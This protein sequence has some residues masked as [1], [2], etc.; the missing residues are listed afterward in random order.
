M[1]YIWILSIL[2]IAGCS[3]ETT[4]KVTQET[5]F[6]YI[7]QL[8]GMGLYLEPTTDK[9]KIEI[10][11]AIEIAKESIC[12]QCD[13]PIVEYHSVTYKEGNQL[14]WKT[15]SYIVCFKNPDGELCS[16]VDA[17]DGNVSKNFGYAPDRDKP[18]N[19]TSG[20][21]GEQHVYGDGK[22]IEIK[23]KRTSSLNHKVSPEK[24]KEV[25][26]TEYKVM[27][28]VGIRLLHKDE[29]NG[30]PSQTDESSSFY[31]VIQGIETGEKQT[32]IYVSA[33]NPEHHF[34]ITVT[35]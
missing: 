13:E 18:F 15:P 35:E 12:E 25:A 6:E 4:N 29:L 22:L 30:M 21:T 17:L 31:Y 2:L 1:K 34:K 14:M 19:K 28:V 11:T 8:D 20:E 9:P 26:L 33:D 32:T 3:S 10:E 5:H 24:A 7:W 16:V 23:T 27:D